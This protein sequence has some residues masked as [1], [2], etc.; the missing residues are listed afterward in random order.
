MQL[1]APL[2][3]FTICIILINPT[4]K[5]QKIK[6]FPL[7]KFDFKNYYQKYTSIK[8]L[9]LTKKRSSI[10]NKFGKVSKF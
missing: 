9:K 6:L 1:K 3:G 8:Q 7:K 2:A 5:T 10:Q 4:C